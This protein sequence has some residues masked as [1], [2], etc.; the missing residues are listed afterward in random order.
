MPLPFTLPPAARPRM[1]VVCF[2]LCGQASSRKDVMRLV[3]SQSPW[4]PAPAKGQSVGCVPRRTHRRGSG[5]RGDWTLRAQRQEAQHTP[6]WGTILVVTRQKLEE[7]RAPA[8][9]ST[10]VSM[11]KAGQG[12]V[13][14]LKL[15]TLNNSSRF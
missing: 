12:R 15:A 5:N 7:G 3:S 6:W 11:G 1:Q 2:E 9:V 8:R 4:I 14:S 13:N 10:G